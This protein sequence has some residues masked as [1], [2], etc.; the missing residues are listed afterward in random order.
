MG[1][2]QRRHQAGLA[3]ESLDEGLVAHQGG[4]QDLYRHLTTEGEVVSQVDGAGTAGSD[5]LAQPVPPA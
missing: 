5:G 3:P 2:G 1:I 4:V